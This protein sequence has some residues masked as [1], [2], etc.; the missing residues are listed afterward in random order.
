MSSQD[1]NPYAPPRQDDSPG[2]ATV[3]APSADGVVA[4]TAL[5]SEE[6][7]RAG[8]LLTAT[9]A[10]WRHAH[11]RCIRGVQCDHVLRQPP[12]QIATAIALGVAGWFLWPMLF[13]PAARR[14]LANK[15]DA[16]R[17]VTWRFSPE[18]VEITT[19][20]SYGRFDW[21]TIHRFLEGPETFVL[22]ISEVAVQVIPKRVF[23][24][25]AVDALRAMFP[26]RITP[27]KKRSRVGLV[28]ALSML[29][30]LMFLGMW[31]FLQSDR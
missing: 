9:N 19:A 2:A 28:L 13:S 7:M 11:H 25:G 30:L 18:S 17:T 20:T 6:D 24:S 16:E 3:A 21:W 31:Q 4:G 1:P 5:L 12:I 22:Y 10:R 8:I 29:L 14:S 15:S 27:R 26:Q 23:R